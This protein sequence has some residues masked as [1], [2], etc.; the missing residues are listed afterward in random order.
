VYESSLL[1]IEVLIVIINPVAGQEKHCQAL[2]AV[3]SGKPTPSSPY[4]QQQQWALER[5]LYNEVRRLVWSG[6]EVTSY[7]KSS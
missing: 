7:G 6:V 3:G 2:E 5:V 1:T 4:E